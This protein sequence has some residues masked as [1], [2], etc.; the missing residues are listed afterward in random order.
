M[1]LDQ[2]DVG[3]NRVDMV[4]SSRA[5][6]SPPDPG[7]SISGTIVG[8]RAIRMMRRLSP[9]DPWL[10]LAK[11]GRDE[12]RRADRR[13]SPKAR[14]Q[15][16]RCSSAP[17][18]V[19]MGAAAQ[20]PGLGHQ[21]L[22]RDLWDTMTEIS[23]GYLVAGSRSDRPDLPHG[24]RLV[25][26]PP[27]RLPDRVR[28]LDILAC[29]A[30]SVALNGILPGEPRHPGAALMFTTIIAGATFAAIL[31]AYAV[32]KIFFTVIGAFTYLYLFLSVGGS[33]DIKFAFV[34]EHPWATAIFLVGGSYLIFLL[35]RS[36]WPKV[37]AWWED[38]KDGGAILAEPRKYMIR[39]FTPSL[40]RLDREPR[41]DGRLPDRVRHSGQLPHADADSAAATRSRTSPRR[42][43]WRGVNQAFNVASLNGVATA[44]EATRTRSRSS[45]SPLRGTSSSGS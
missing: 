23:F 13:S 21:R 34:H 1:N 30:A 42:A 7:M 14:F 33:F 27:L 31:G 5:D 37:V 12:H 16:A 11:A 18:V 20:L 8:H 41:R 40:H 29:Y 3:Q 36:F 39:V 35:I 15:L 44:Q 25:L 10:V 26:D 2:Q 24:L 22:V 43:G 28:W 6:A 4:R 32:E 38:A 17:R 19:V 45:S 9:R